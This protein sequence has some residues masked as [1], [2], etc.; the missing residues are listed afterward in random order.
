MIEN[1]PWTMITTNSTAAGGEFH[2]VS[3]WRAIAPGE[4][5]ARASMEVAAITGT[6]MQVAAAVQT[7]NDP[8]NPDA[9]AAVITAVTTNGVKDPNAA[10]TTITVDGKRWIRT[11]YSVKVTSGT[12]WVRVAGRV[13]TWL[14]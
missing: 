14:P 7:A 1:M 4:T 13:E 9:H 2:A 12:G 6:G 5:A 3:P 8:R 11:G 10:A